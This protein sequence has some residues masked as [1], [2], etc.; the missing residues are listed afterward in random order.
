MQCLKIIMESSLV[1]FVI[2]SLECA[3]YY[4]AQQNPTGYCMFHIKSQLY[5][6]V[7]VLVC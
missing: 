2:V 5:N 7:N 4:M 3:L 6:E 1:F